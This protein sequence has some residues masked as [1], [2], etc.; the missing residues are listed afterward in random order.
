MMSSRSRASWEKILEEVNCRV[1]NIISNEH[2]DA[3]LLR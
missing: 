2:M 1:L 3:Y